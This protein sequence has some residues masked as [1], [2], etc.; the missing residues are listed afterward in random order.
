M[1]VFLQS[2][3]TANKKIDEKNCLRIKP[4]ERSVH[5]PKMKFDVSDVRRIQIKDEFQPVTI[6]LDL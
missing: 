4:L 2:N 6:S 3:R 5:L 1:N